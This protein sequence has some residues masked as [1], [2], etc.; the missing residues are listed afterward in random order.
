MTMGEVNTMGT[1]PPAVG[2]GPAVLATR[3]SRVIY[4]EADTELLGMSFKAFSTLDQLRDHGG[5]PQQKLSEILCLD[6][7]YL[8][9]TLNEL[10]DAGYAI[11]RRDPSDRRRHIVEITPSG[12]EAVEAAER[13]IRSVEDQVLAALTPDERVLLSE[14]LARALEGA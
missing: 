9:L 3:L 1:A 7:N 14:L 11:R 2:A 4:R 13:G 12:L 8:V 10:E 6:P 5:I